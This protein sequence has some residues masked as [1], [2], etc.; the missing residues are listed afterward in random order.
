MK[1]ASFWERVDGEHVLVF[2]TDTAL[3]RRSNNSID[4]FLDWDFVGAPWDTN[5]KCGNGGLS[6][7]KKSSTL[8]VI[9]RDNGS[10]AYNEDQFFCERLAKYGYKVAPYITSR[11]FSIEMA[12]FDLPAG[13]HQVFYH[14]RIG[15]DWL[16]KI[17]ET[18]P[19]ARVI[20]PPQC[21]LTSCAADPKVRA[22][23][24]KTLVC[25]QEWRDKVSNRTKLKPPIQCDITAG[26]VP[27]EST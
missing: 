19:E 12:Y 2:Q 7:R 11:R 1:N 24:N 15:T 20:S 22:M 5:S 8:D 17:H 18:C 13:V 25:S 3:C 23:F 14:H 9:R 10:S 26:W 16:Y 21:R 4:D 6:L 27:K